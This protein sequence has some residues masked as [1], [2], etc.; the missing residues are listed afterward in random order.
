[1]PWLKRSAHRSP[2]GPTTWWLPTN[3]PCQFGPAW[4][5]VV[6]WIPLRKGLDPYEHAGSAHLLRLRNSRTGAI[7]EFSVCQ[8]H[9]TELIRLELLTGQAVLVKFEP[10]PD[11]AA[12]ARRPAL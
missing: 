7:H 3:L 1:M 6:P 9:R 8:R 11:Y 4:E 10:T 12:T 2:V 5:F